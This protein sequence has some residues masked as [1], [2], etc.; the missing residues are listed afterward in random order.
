[1]LFKVD[2]NLL[3]LD[4]IRNIPSYEKHFKELNTKKKR[5][6]KNEKVMVSKVA[7]AVL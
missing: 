3:L 5:Y 6:E 4:A 1:M 7:S 2:I